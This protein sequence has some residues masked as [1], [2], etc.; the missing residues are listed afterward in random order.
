M[1]RAQRMGMR[2]DSPT[3]RSAPVPV[4]APVPAV[5]PHPL[6][7]PKGLPMRVAITGATGFVGQELV[8]VLREAG[9][10]PVALVRDL[11]RGEAVLGVDVE[12]REYDGFDP[13]SVR[14]ALAGAEGI[15]N[16]AGEGI[17]SRKWN[18]AYKQALH[19]SRVRTT[20]TLYDALHE[21]PL[22]ER[23]RVL[24]S[25]SA[26][27]IYGPREE[28]DPCIE[29]E[30]AATNFKPA[31]FLANLCREWE[32]A[33]RRV[34]RL[35]LRVAR[36]RIGVVLGR[37]GGALAKMEKP[38][39]MGVGG[40]M[41]SG[42]QVVSW[43]HRADLCRALVYALEHDQLDRAFNATAPEP[44]S[45]LKFSQALARALKRPCIFP[46]PSF[47]AKLAL[48]KAASVLLTG[49]RVL[50]ARLEKAGF[51]FRFSTID[52]AMR[53]LYGSPLPAA[54]A[55]SS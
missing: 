32:L 50:P 12:M 51:Q 1:A 42:R 26:V 16:L 23:P 10:E 22:A 20:N 41:G 48:G 36:A 6:V 21:V 4:P 44:V 37:G 54:P 49:Q 29:D 25:G 40:R 27:G 19:E 43:I 17:F 39:K 13:K 14:E 2:E 53:D 33:A 35:G 24:V 31:D 15:I 47:A 55:V 28:N 5:Y 38:F 11:E 9:H 52:A 18:K 8:S 45:N 3:P 30:F 34:E 7:L 46:L